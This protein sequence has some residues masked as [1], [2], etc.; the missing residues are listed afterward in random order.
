VRCSGIDGD[1]MTR[2][3]DGVVAEPKRQRRR[4]GPVQRKQSGEYIG[5]SVS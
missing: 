5:G 1:A 4:V 3:D 2:Y